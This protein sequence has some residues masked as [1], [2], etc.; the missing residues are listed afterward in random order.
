MVNP[1]SNRKRH[2]A[3]VLALGLLLLLQTAA[4]R[5]AGAA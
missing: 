3:L 5:R 4:D 1:L 2:L